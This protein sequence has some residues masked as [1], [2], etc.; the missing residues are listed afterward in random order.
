M[1]PNDDIICSI[2][3][4]QDEGDCVLCDE[5]REPYHLKCVGED[6]SGVTDRERERSQPTTS[7]PS[8]ESKPGSRTP[9]HRRDVMHEISMLFDQMKACMEKGNETLK[10]LPLEK[11]CYACSRTDAESMILCQKCDRYCRTIV[12]CLEMCLLRDR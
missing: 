7:S 5:C 4:V 10:V 12:C 1:A 2:C 9:T 3:T 11:Q 8:D 6:E